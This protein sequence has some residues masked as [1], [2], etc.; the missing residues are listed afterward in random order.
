MDPCETCELS[1]YS[2]NYDQT[3]L[4]GHKVPLSIWIISTRPP[5]DSDCCPF[6][7]KICCKLPKNNISRNYK[8]TNKR[9]LSCAKK[10]MSNMS[11][12]SVTEHGCKHA[13]HCGLTANGR[14]QRIKFQFP[15]CINLFL[16]NINCC[17]LCFTHCAA[18]TIS[19]ENV[20]AHKVSNEQH[21]RGKAQIS[22]SQLSN[23]KFLSRLSNYVQV[24]D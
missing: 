12:W 6:A 19:K 23:Y 10:F 4:G 24:S 11:L 7:P 9:L 20:I 8:L 16:R 13:R 14:S 18:I 17:F 22:D 1:F 3:D 15:H 21:T 2:S 5:T